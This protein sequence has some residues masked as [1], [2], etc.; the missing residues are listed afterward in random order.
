MS[1]KRAFKR[2]GVGHLYLLAQPNARAE[3][4]PTG[5]EPTHINRAYAVGRLL[6]RV[7][8]P[9]SENDSN[10]ILLTLD[11]HLYAASSEP[12][13]RAAK[14]IARVKVGG[15]GMGIASAPAGG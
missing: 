6:H 11:T 10:S 7:V 13:R 4:R 2:K 14:P 8:R 15:S 3:R 1:S 9:A 12:P 5:T